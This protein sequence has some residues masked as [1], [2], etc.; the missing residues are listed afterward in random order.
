M[1]KLYIALQ[2]ILVS[3]GMFLF[4]LGCNDSTEQETKVVEPQLDYEYL[5][6]ADSKKDKNSYLEFRVYKVTIDS[7]T[8]IIASKRYDGGLTL[9]DKK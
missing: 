3:V 8:Y 9:L 2:A 6:E 5:G 4:I 7:I 1:K